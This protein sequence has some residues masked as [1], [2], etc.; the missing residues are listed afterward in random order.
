MSDTILKYNG[1]TEH[2]ETLPVEWY[3]DEQHYQREMAAIWYKNW[4]Y[5]CRADALAQPRAFRTQQIGSQNIL[6]LRT[7]ESGL[8][9]FHNTCRHRG[10]V[11]VTETEGVMRS[12]NIM[13]PYHNW[14]YSQ[15]GELIRT[16]SKQC[17]ASFDMAEHSLYD[18]AV[19]D[20]N[21][22]VF[23]N[24]AGQDAKP[25]EQCIGADA[26]A[27]ANWPAAALKVGASYSKTM[28][29]NW[30]VFW[31]NYN[32]CLHCPGVHKDLSKLVPIYR[33]NYMTACD[34][35]NWQ[36]NLKSD[37]P[38]LRGGMRAGAQTWTTDGQPIGAVFPN[39]SDAE[40]TQAFT[41][42]DVHPT[43]FIVGHVDYMRIVRIMP[44]GP[45]KT[46]IQA[47]WLFMEET[48]N[49]PA[50]DIAPA[51]D[52][53]KQV[54]AEDAHVSELNQAGMHSI[55]HK[56]GSLMPEEYAVHDFHNWVRAQLAASE[57]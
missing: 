17:P 55:R 15:Q 38:A 4:V 22:F 35:P 41:Y 3:L 53:V 8:Q 7:E 12:K 51:V 39:L 23:V 26:N 43:A 45:E 6:V 47:E 18:V 49:D 10:S 30:K 42:V 36:E 50:V 9:A 29:C 46:E 28:D 32:E 11:L 16:S 2:K 20:W 31:E 48:L 19:V 24:L 54:M 37:D 14:T 13:C 1:L 57:S 27:F 5:V 34:D 52:F 33:R 44:L 25:I 40:R 56:K 21:G